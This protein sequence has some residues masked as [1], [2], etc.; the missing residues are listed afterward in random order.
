ML[1]PDQQAVL[2][3]AEPAIFA[4][5]PGGWGRKGAT[6]VH[7]DAADEAAVLSAL[8]L[9]WRNKAPKSLIEAAP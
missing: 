8:R 5:V 3:E 6:S 2:T 7:L 9:A 1:V 4:P